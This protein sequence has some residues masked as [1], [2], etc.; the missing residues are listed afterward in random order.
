MKI[1]NTNPSSLKEKT[2][3]KNVLEI[4]NV[5]LFYDS[6]FGGKKEIEE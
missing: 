2:K 6:N 5:K 4:I 3:H 1:V